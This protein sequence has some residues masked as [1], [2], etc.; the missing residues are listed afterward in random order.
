MRRC[1]RYLVLVLLALIIGA[2]GC[3]ASAGS[4]SKDAS[5]PT[6]GGG[7]AASSPFG[8]DIEVDGLTVRVEKPFRKSFSPQAVEVDVTFKTKGPGDVKTPNPILT[9]LGK[10]YPIDNDIANYPSEVHDTDS[11]TWAWTPAPSCQKGS[12]SVGA[13]TFAF[14]SVAM[15]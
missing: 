8:N 4:G 1:S 15:R 6:T 2:A 12:F 3:G 11:G 9:C 13:H 14:T 5:T 10:E 7:P